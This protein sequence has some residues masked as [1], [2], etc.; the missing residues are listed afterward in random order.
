ML[1][2]IGDVP[3]MTRTW[4]DAV[5]ALITEQDEA[6]VEALRDG[7][8]SPDVAV[9]PL[10]PGE[11]VSATDPTGARPP[12]SATAAWASGTD[13]RSRRPRR[14]LTAVLAAAA[15]AV[16]GTAAALVS[17]QSQGSPAAAEGLQSSSGAPSDQGA[18]SA[19]SD[20]A[21]P[22]EPAAAPPDTASLDA[23]PSTA[24]AATD[25]SATGTDAP[26]Q[27][28]SKESTTAGPA[29]LGTTEAYSLAKKINGGSMPSDAKVGILKCD[30]GWASGRFTSTTY[31]EAAVVYEYD[32]ASW[33]AVDL[34]S[35][36]CQ[37]VV[38]GAPSDV[39]T[40]LNC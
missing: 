9:V 19:T 18:D 11:P 34:G 17:T 33:N 6:V 24:D 4:P 3:A 40:S 27:P 5:L 22:Y 23:A 2:R 38:R 14:V 21:N 28:P 12:E 26:A 10:L 31:G 39:R 8:A 15:L 7:G 20:S 32:G 29:C 25:P 35:D 30:D 16:G 37:G 1:A 13:G 36:V